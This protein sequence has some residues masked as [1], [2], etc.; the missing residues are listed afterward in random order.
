[1]KRFGVEL[2]PESEVLP[3]IGAKEGIAHIALCF[4][5]AGDIV[6]V[7]DP[8]YPIYN[9]G[10]V[11]AG[12]KTYYMPLLQKNKFLPELNLIPEDVLKKAKLMWI[13]YPNNPTGVVAELDFYNRVVEF[14]KKHD[15]VVCHDDPYSEISFDDYKP[16]SFLQA[17][18]AK[19]IGVEFHSLSKSYN[20]AGWRI[21]MVVGNAQVI[22]AL[23]IVKSNIDTGIPQ[24]IQYA[25]I[26][27]LNGSQAPIEKRNMIYQRRRDLLIEVLNDIGMEAVPPKAGLYIW[28]KV[29]AGYTS[30]ELTNDLL[31]NIGI[32]V[33]PGTGYGECG[34]GYIRFSLTLS[35]VTLVKG[36]SRLSGWKNEKDKFKAKVRK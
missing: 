11:L 33:T 6:L 13:N 23:N 20:M 29:P 27:A 12:G 3:L 26:E 5:D 31:D 16:A 18:G 32:V 22:K 4:I 10:T 9:S 1:M 2:D 25:A 34:E 28:A 14:A 36:L 30:I 21:G 19:D 17:E 15:I 7:P 35:D 8:S 24:A